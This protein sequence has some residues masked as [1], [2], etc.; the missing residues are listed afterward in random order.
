MNRI[1]V[2]ANLIAALFIVVIAIGL[3]QVP[4]KALK[5]TRR[6]RY[7]MWMTFAGL[8][9]EIVTCVL[10]GRSEWNLLLCG[11]NY[12]ASILTDCIV[13]TY[14]FY[15]YDL[16]SESSKT[17]TKRFAYAVSALCL[18]DICILTVLTLSGKLFHIQN[19]YF[20]AGSC[21]SYMGVIPGICFIAMIFL[22][23]L[24]FKNFRIQNKLFVVL[25]VLVPALGSIILT[26][27]KNIRYGYMVSAISMNVIYVIIQSRLVAEAAADARLYNEISCRDYLT[28][29]RN[30]RGFQ[31]Y[32][33]SVDEHKEIG[34]AF[35]DI[36]SLKET[37]DT[38]GHEAGDRLIR[39]VAEL[40]R[41][42]I[43]TGIPCRISGDEFVCVIE[44]ISDQKL[45][46]LMDGFRQLLRQNDRIAAVGY[47]HGQ[48]KQIGELIKASEQMM[49]EDKEDYYRE[50]GRNRR[51]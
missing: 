27:D 3:Y 16:I 35:I 4:K 28:E 37:N 45:S 46:E 43:P 38:Q 50:T 41:K 14:S 36:N 39:R 17:F 44:N 13:I 12:L 25:I 20:E 34:I 9:I 49:Y 42:G 26:M 30:R 31:E 15:L 48:K 51:R 33:D 24:E 18:L 6:F 10:E 32:L 47:A 21:Y 40:I 23:I 22:Y 11:S 1:L 8:M 2:A 5:P 19:G 29:L 7:C